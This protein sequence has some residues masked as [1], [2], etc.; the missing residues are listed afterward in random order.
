[1]GIAIAAMMPMIATTMRSSISVKPFLP[2]M[3]PVR[4]LAVSRPISCR[5]LGMG[6]ADAEWFG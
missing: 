6:S 3:D 2:R 4:F 1:L 5:D